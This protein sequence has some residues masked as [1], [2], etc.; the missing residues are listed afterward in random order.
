[1]IYL[2]SARVK[3]IKN[4][5]QKGERIPLTDKDCEI[6][7][8]VDD[9]LTLRGHIVDQNGIVD[10]PQ[11]NIDNKT[12]KKGSKASHTVGSMTIDAIKSTPIWE[13]TTFYK[14]SL[15][16]NQI[17]WD[18]DFLEISHQTILDMD[19]PEIQS[20]LKNAYDN[21]RSKILAGD[22][23]KNIVS[24]CG[25]AVFDGYNHHNSYRYRITNKAMQKIKNMSKSRDSR[26]KL[27]EE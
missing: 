22:R 2:K 15:N 19:L 21:L 24:D 18:P 14:K 9:Q 11:Y 8:W 4:N 25:W 20:A 10:L 17:E 27:F 13:E 7:Q 23:R 3:E 16:Q 1:M 26:K 5:I 12:R 6:G